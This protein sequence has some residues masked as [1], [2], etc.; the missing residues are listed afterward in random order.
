MKHLLIKLNKISGTGKEFT[1]A[2]P[3]I[4]P[5]LGFVVHCPQPIK[6]AHQRLC[7]Y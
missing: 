1:T 6:N 2:L 7:Y 3:N 4:E 5:T